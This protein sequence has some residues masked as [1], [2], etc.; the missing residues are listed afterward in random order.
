MWTALIWPSEAHFRKRIGATQLEGDAN[1]DGDADGADFLAWQR[2][3]TGG[4]SVVASAPVTEP[5]AS[6]LLPTGYGAG[7]LKRRGMLRR[8]PFVMP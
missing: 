8:K 1:G 7:V 3:L 2:Q 6:I 5:A 4:T